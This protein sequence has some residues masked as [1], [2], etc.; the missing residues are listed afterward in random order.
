MEIKGWWVIVAVLPY[1]LVVTSAFIVAFNDDKKKSKG[2]KGIAIID[3]IT[4]ISVMLINFHSTILN[5]TSSRFKILMV[6][7]IILFIINILLEIWMYKKA[8]LVNEPNEKKLKWI[9]VPFED[10]ANYRD[11]AKSFQKSFGET[12]LL[13]V[14]ISIILGFN[15]DRSMDSIIVLSFIDLF[16]IYYLFICILNVVTYHYSYFIKIKLSLRKPFLEK[17]PML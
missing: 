3:L 17:I 2:I 11:M 7:M 4:R 10:R 1:I 6:S 5:K 8:L 14:I 9:E 15:K 16:F 13:I 12:I